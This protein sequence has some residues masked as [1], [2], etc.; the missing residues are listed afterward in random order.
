[1][2]NLNIS[3]LANYTFDVK[4]T[5]AHALVNESNNNAQFPN[6]NQ[7]LNDLQNIPLNI[8]Q[9]SNSSQHNQNQ[10]QII[11]QHINAAQNNILPQQVKDVSQSN[12]MS[13]DIIEQEFNKIA[14][15][16]VNSPV[17]N[18]LPNIKQDLSSNDNHQFSINAIMN[19]L[20]EE[21][22]DLNK[23]NEEKKQ[24]NNVPK[25]NM[26][27]LKVIHETDVNKQEN[28][29]EK[30]MEQQQYNMDKNI[31]K[32]SDKK[33]NETEINEIENDFDEDF[34]I[35]N[36]NLSKYAE[37]KKNDN[38]FSEALN[39]SINSKKFAEINTGLKKL[40]KM[41]QLISK[42]IVVSTFFQN[43]FNE[44]IRKSNEELRKAN[45][46]QRKANEEQRKANEEQ[47]KANEEQRKA[48]NDFRSAIKELLSQN[49]ILVKNLIGN[50]PKQG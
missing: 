41:N 35:L 39:Q 50:L 19:Q 46:E 27:I 45:E 33:K 4:Y 12:N 49:S 23:P 20:I 2:S 22:I 30:K 6:D 24:D 14:N 42:T 17:Q 38:A 31:S 18:Q 28:S 13:H 11:N 9:Q 3:N 44:E 8:S 1:M 5:A 40:T 26:N 15:N 36:N 34:N 10:G 48:N 29:M 7:Q 43:Q 25:N 32:E 21:I 37:K 16:Y 47:R